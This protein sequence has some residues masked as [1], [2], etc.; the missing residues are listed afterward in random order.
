MDATSLTMLRLAWDLETNLLI[1]LCS[2]IYALPICPDPAASCA[3]KKHNKEDLNADT[4][5]NACRVDVHDH[6]P[7]HQGH[8]SF[9]FLTPFELV[10]EPFASQMFLLSALTHGRF[11]SS[12][13]LCLCF[14]LSLP[15]NVTRPLVYFS[16][17]TGK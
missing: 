10:Y 17:F 14:C 4:T 8:V 3:V 16:G 2:F 5:K 1:S 15:R 12:L 11:A 6:A 9:S 13:C 7:V